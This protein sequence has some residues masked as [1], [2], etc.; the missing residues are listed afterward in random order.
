[1]LDEELQ[2]V[3]NK[4]VYSTS[5]NFQRV[6]KHLSHQPT[7]GSSIHVRVSCRLRKVTDVALVHLSLQ[8]FKLSLFLLL[9]SLFLLLNLLLNHFLFNLLGAR[10]TLLKVQL[11][12]VVITRMLFL[13]DFGLEVVVVHGLIWRLARLPVLGQRCFETLFSDIEKLLVLLDIHTQEASVLL[14]LFLTWI[15]LIV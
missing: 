15:V 13:E 4:L 2:L 8:V 11:A 5:R 12:I 7:V 6:S 3:I 10:L 9:F 14:Y 1:M